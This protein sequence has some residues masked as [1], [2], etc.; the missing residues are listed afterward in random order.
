ME[1]SDLVLGLRVLL[2]L[3]CVL[4][5]LWFAARRLSGT[6]S[7]KRQRTAALSVVARQSLGGRTGV[8]VVEIGDRRLLVGVSEHGVNLLSEL[9]SSAD[10]ETV[11]GVEPLTVGGPPAAGAPPIDPSPA[12]RVPQAVAAAGVRAARVEI[13]PAELES[14]L[15][16]NDV[17]GADVLGPD[18]AATGLPLTDLSTPA[19]RMPAVPTPRSPLEG[20]I[21]DATVWRQAV[22]AAQRRTTRR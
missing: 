3:A 1:S 14:W 20:S 21:L 2:S 8:A 4:G 10:V 19:A 6:A 16:Q 22:A 5:L 12:P 7:A 17:L 9:G 13:D 18:L 11:T 15:L